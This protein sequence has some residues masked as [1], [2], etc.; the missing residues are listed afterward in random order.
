[1]IVPVEDMQVVTKYAPKIFDDL[2]W[3]IQTNLVYKLSDKRREFFRD[4]FLNHGFGASWDC[5]IR[6]T[7]RRQEEL[8]EQN[9]YFLNHEDGHKSTM[10]VSITKGLVKKEP[11]EI[12]EY[13]KA[14]G[15]SY[16][17]FERITDDGNAKENS[18]RPP[19]IETDAWLL[20]MWEQ[21]LEFKT[22]EWIG[23]MLMSEIATAVVNRNH[24]ANRCRNCEQ[25]LL[26]INAD[27]TIAGCPNS[28]PVDYWG[29]I[30]DNIGSMLTGPRRM[31]RISCESQRDPRCYS[32]PAFDVCN[33]DCQHLAWEGDICGAPKSL[34]KKL[35]QEQD[36]ETYKKL[37]LN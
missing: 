16:I 22:H 31:E 3:S 33:G 36:Y 5:D 7:N 8:F 25:S 27:G 23:N 18:V 6:F 24:T 15:Y 1:M 30:D 35:K 19:N 13:A 37:I 26:T 14:M 17:L 32:C 34:W 12:M 21:C 10:T 11:I 28:A 2:S 4:T 20:K 9:S 29:H